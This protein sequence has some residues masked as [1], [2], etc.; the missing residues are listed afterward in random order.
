[1]EGLGACGIEI[2]YC[3]IDPVD[4][5]RREGNLESKHDVP[6]EDFVCVLNRRHVVC[7]RSPHHARYVMLIDEIKRMSL[8]EVVKV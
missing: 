1:M 3:S 7:A 5:S 8:E 2:N 6:P 4:G